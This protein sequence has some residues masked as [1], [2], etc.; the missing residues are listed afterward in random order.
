M[1]KLHVGCGKRFLPG[2]THVDAQSYSHIDV[3][4]P[5]DQISTAFIH[6]SIDEIYACH[7]LEHIPRGKISSTLKDLSKLLKV[8]GFLRI[9]VPD[10]E[11]VVSAYGKEGI[12]LY[13]DLYGLIWGGQRD[14][15]DY[16]HAGFDYQTL[17]AFLEEAGFSFIERYEWREFLPDGYDDYSRSYLP[18]MDFDTGILMSLNILA[19]KASQ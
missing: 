11:A 18:H 14:S 17:K 3:V 4:V 7:V 12:R 15:Y 10:F 9:A 6:D 16:H 2:W 13:P 19:Q 1:K 5:L 8:G